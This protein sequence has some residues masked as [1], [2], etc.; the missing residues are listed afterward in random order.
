M[1]FL[2]INVATPIAI[3]LAIIEDFADAKSDTLADTLSLKSTICCCVLQETVIP[4]RIP[5]VQLLLML[6]SMA[7]QG[8]LMEPMIM[9]HLYQS[10]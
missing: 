10:L 6:V 9:F 3:V 8:V 1:T 7:T 4:V 2:A 5:V